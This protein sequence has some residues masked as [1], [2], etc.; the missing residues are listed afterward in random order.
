MSEP[1]T[2][3]DCDCNTGTKKCQ[4]CGLPLCRECF[5]IDTLC[6]ACNRAERHALAA[7]RDAES[8]GEP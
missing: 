4:K 7:K 8:K 6:F 3:V 1:E 2:C 5:K